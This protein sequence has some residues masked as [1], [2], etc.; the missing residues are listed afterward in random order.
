MLKFQWAMAIQLLS[1]SLPFSPL[2][3]SPNPITPPPLPPSLFFKCFSSSSSSTSTS[4]STHSPS[5]SQ[6]DPFIKKKVVMRVGYVGTHYRGLQMQRDQHELSSIET[7]L[8]PYHFIFV[9]LM[10]IVLFN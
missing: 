8:I 7:L 1:C 4:T 6:W 10:S 2:S 5:P 9:Y 3:P